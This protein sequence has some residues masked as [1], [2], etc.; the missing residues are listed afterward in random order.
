L[1][2][3][4]VGMRDNWNGE[5]IESEILID[6]YLRLWMVNTSTHCVHLKPFLIFGVCPAAA[7][8]TFHIH[9]HQ[10]G[11]I[12]LLSHSRSRDELKVILEHPSSTPSGTHLP[13]Q[14]IHQ[15]TKNK[16]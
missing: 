3:D 13:V 1:Y 14:S 5:M 9:P 7:T 2:N 15:P 11:D 16:K 12:F 6:V 4:N 8:I 10:A